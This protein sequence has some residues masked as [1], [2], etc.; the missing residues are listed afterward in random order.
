M[1][2]FKNFN[3][4][5]FFRFS[6]KFCTETPPPFLSSFL[7]SSFIFTPHPPSRSRYC[8]FPSIYLSFSRSL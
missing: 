6:F 3:F 7:C 5:L 4:C 8:L 2:T 1:D